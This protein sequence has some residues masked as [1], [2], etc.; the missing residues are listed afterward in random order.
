M[1]TDEAKLHHEMTEFPRPLRVP[2]IHF[3]SR[4]STLQS[5]FRLSQ[6]KRSIQRDHHI[7]HRNSLRHQQLQHMTDGKLRCV[8]KIACRPFLPVCRLHAFRTRSPM[9]SENSQ[10][11]GRACQTRDFPAGEFGVAMANPDN[12]HFPD[13]SQSFPERFAKS[14]LGTQISNPAFGIRKMCVL[15][16]SYEHTWPRGSLP[17]SFSVHPGRFLGG[18]VKR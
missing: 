13:V 6:R 2:N 7:D 1:F 5:L 3:F 10:S 14:S 4:T 18:R 16:V 12:P 9:T 17:S 8:G 11:G 15:D